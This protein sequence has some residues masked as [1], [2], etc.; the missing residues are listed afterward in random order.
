MHYGQLILPVICF[1]LFIENRFRFQ[2]N[3]IKVFILLCLFGISFFAFSYKLGF[4]SV[5]GFTLPMAYYIG[6]C[7]RNDNPDNFK[8][9][10]YLL[11]IS[12]AFHVCLN[13][14]YEYHMPYF[15]EIKGFSRIADSST[16]YDFWTGSD[17]SSTA[18]AINLNLSIGCLYYLFRYERNKLVRI[19]VLIPFLIGMVYCIMMGRRTPVL[20]I[21]ISLFLC[22]FF[23]SFIYKS[24]SERARMTI[25]SL[26]VGAFV[27]GALVFV[28]YLTDFLGVK[29]FLDDTYI[30]AKFKLGLLDD[31]R[32]ELLLKAYRL[33]PH[34][35]WGGQHISSSA[36]LQIHELWMDIYD[37][38]G[39]VPYVLMIVSS[40]N[41]LL[42]VIRLLR[43]SDAKT[44]LKVL[45]IGVFFCIVIQMFIEPIMTGESLFLIMAVLIGTMSEKFA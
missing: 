9:V 39:I 31:E 42:S 10:I 7:I 8:K 37:F 36:G 5:M 21:L 18:T 23:E 33:A 6:S 15:D 35:L 1:L 19:L 30:V 4:Y 40:I 32:I 34:Y 12:M 41:Y 25:L 44:S 45:L 13:F 27:L 24:L 38:A 20:M 29:R 11:A 26:F 16:H 14:Y 43:S 22:F 17:V 3:D 2:V 28:M